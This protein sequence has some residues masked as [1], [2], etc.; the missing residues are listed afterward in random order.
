MNKLAFGCSHTEGVGVEPHESWPAL[1]EAINFGK[2]GVSADY[3]LRIAPDILESHSP[4]V[5]YILWPDWT[6]F[7]YIDEADEIKQ[8]LATDS[9]RIN[10]MET[11]TDEW[12]QNNFD[13]H[14][15]R[16]KELC[17]ENNIKL[18]DIT[19]DD[20]IPY[21]DYSDRWPLS[22]LGHHYSPVWHGWVADIFKKL[23]NEKT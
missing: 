15:A 8:S 21:I 1:I 23:E 12:L 20:L 18:V 16:M 10:F 11:A 7:E 2:S 17:L 3:I 4:S 9:N 19:L 5:V 6:R 14:V 13:K 22:K